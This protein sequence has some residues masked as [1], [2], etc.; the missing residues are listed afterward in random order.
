MLG[1]HASHPCRTRR[2]CNREVIV[3]ID[4]RGASGMLIGH[5]GGTWYDGILYVLEQMGLGSHM[6]TGSLSTAAARGGGTGAI[7]AGLI[8]TGVG[9]TLPRSVMEC[10]CVLVLRL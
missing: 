10:V 9:G 5:G 6:W 1:V 7:G 2:G 3:V 8:G 4:E